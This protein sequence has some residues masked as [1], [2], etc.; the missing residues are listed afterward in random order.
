MQAQEVCRVE[1]VL[2]TILSESLEL[3]GFDLERVAH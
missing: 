3:T 2:D 1:F